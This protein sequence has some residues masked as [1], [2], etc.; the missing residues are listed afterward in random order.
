VLHSIASFTATEVIGWCFV[1]WLPCDSPR[2]YLHVCALKQ[3]P[4][5]VLLIAIVVGSEHGRPSTLVQF[6][7][8]LEQQALYSLARYGT[9]V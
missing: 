6:S 3:K 2:C 9:T 4:W 7:C 8:Q 5:S 1:G